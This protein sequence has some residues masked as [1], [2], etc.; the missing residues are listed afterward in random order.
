MMGDREGQVS[1]GT[2]A[3]VGPHTPGPPPLPSLHGGLQ[4]P[5]RLPST[6]LLSHHRVGP[7]VACSRWLG[8]PFPHS[9]SVGTGDR[10]WPVWVFI[11]P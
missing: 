3:A 11:C 2:A 5:S 1:T 10:Q 9:C 6:L 8:S 4:L 7:G